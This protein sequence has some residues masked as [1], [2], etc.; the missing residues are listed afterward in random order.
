MPS[1]PPIVQPRGTSRVPG[2]PFDPW[3]R[4]AGTDSIPLVRKPHE[5]MTALG[6]ALLWQDPALALF[7]PVLG[8][9]DLR[10]W[11]GDLAGELTAAASAGGLAQRLGFP[12]GIAATLELKTHL[13]RDLAKAYKAGD[14]AALKAIATGDLP[15]L[16]QR[17]RA[18]W[19]RHRD[20]WMTTYKPFGWEVIEGRYGTLMARLETLQERL[21]GYLAGTLA[22]YRDRRRTH[23]PYRSEIG[24]IHVSQPDETRAVSSSNTLSPHLVG[25]ASSA[26]SL[27]FVESVRWGGEVSGPTSRPRD[28]RHYRYCDG[29]RDGDG[30]DGQRS[31]VHWMF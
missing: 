30:I 31:H 8:D 11:Y 16:R 6:R 19:K 15:E 25:Y 2:C 29:Y 13:R 17:A 28:L 20:M 7:D 21:D 12:A 1:V 9:H 23:N 5:S 24:D 27:R 4:A 10:A 3:V 18:L 22:N 26:L 14:R